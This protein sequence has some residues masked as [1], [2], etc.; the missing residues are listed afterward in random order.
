MLFWAGSFHVH[1][2]KVRL[3][4][5]CIAPSPGKYW[6]VQNKVV[7]QLPTSATC[8]WA[9]SISVVA[10]DYSPES[11][12][13]LCSWDGTLIQNKTTEKRSWTRGVW[14][15]RLEPEMKRYQGKGSGTSKGPLVLIALAGIIAKAQKKWNK[16]LGV[17]YRKAGLIMAKEFEV[18]R[19]LHFYLYSNFKK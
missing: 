2:I 11:V 19:D 16:G 3:L 4:A 14:N 10:V 6:P 5:N 18:R 15:Y 8:V 17:W 1:G 12:L 7:W 9:M 13:Y